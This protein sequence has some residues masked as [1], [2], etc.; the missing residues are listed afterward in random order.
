VA[1]AYSVT[2]TQGGLATTSAP[3][4]ITGLEE[5]LLSRSVK[6]YPNPAQNYV[7]VD[8]NFVEKGNLKITLLDYLGRKVYEETIKKQE[9]NLLYSLE[10][11]NLLEGLYLLFFEIGEQR[12]LKRVVKE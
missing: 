3:I 6:L 12:G 2:V 5:T 1:G 7:V 10:T 11:K 8:F 4:N 9:Q